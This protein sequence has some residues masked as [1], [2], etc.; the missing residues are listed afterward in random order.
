M[1]IF[2]KKSVIACNSINFTEVHSSQVTKWTQ[3][4]SI[5]DLGIRKTNFHK[6]LRKASAALQQRVILLL[7]D[8]GKLNWYNQIS[9]ELVI[10]NTLT[11]AQI[12]N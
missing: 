7:Q 8:T 2:F 1:T 12:F 10:T 5:C 6:Q 4:Y 9:V 11:F 3:L